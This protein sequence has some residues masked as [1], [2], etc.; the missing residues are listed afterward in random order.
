MTTSVERAAIFMNKRFLARTL[1]AMLALT[2]F[3]PQESK[4]TSECTAAVNAALANA[5]YDVPECCGGACT[6][7]EVCTIIVNGEMWVA[8]DVRKNK[9]NGFDAATFHKPGTNETIVAFRGTEATKENFDPF[10][11]ITDAGSVLSPGSGLTQWQYYDALNYYTEMQG[12]Y[13][14]EK[15][16][17][18]GHS[19]GGSLAMYVGDVTGATTVTFNALGLNSDL[20]D[21][22]SLGNS[23]NTSN[24]YNTDD[25]VKC[26]NEIKNMTIIGNVTTSSSGSSVFCDAVKNAI[27]G[28]LEYAKN[29]WE[30]HK[31]EA[32]KVWRWDDALEEVKN[33]SECKPVVDNLL[34]MLPAHGMGGMESDLSGKCE[35]TSLPQV[36]DLPHEELPAVPNLPRAEIPTAPELPQGGDLPT[37][38]LP[39]VPALP[40]SADLPHAELPAVPDLSHVELPSVPDLREV[41]LP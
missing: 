8:E 39:A 7:S 24:Y 25:P 23:E 4:A 19:L 33:S 1:I 28:C 10:D 40:Q 35:S 6:G 34:V 26:I 11:V 32:W 3:M 16:S 30:E 5:V 20:A 9:L 36:S 15:I 37:T 14:N 12:K 38:E 31:Q 41:K 27:G 22:G 2:L 21:D 13:P 18:T 17:V 29:Y